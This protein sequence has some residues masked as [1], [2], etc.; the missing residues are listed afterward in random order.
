VPGKFEVLA[1]VPQ[2]RLKTVVLPVF[3]LPISATRGRR[4][5]P[6]SGPA[7]A[8]GACEAAAGAD[9]A[10]GAGGA[11]GVVEIVRSRSSAAGS[12]AAMWTC[13]CPTV[14]VW[15][16][17]RLGNHE[18]TAGQ[19]ARQADARLTNLDD[20]GLARLADAEQ[21]AIGEPESPQ[22]RAILDREVRRMHASHGPGAKLGQTDRNGRHRLYGT[23]C[24]TGH[25]D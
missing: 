22:Q 23:G 15:L 25:G 2:R 8:A 18:N 13:A 21:A 11:D 20:A 1:R 9:E 12:M 4:L 5:R 16:G 10:A 6:P 24:E 14:N 7:E 17:G 19:L 3:G